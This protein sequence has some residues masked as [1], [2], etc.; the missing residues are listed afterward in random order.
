VF[1]PNGFIGNHV[2]NS[3][4]RFVFGSQFHCSNFIRNY[5]ETSADLFVSG[6]Q[7][8]PVD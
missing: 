7:F 3:A 8:H 4:N 5:I 2:E 1:H 6:R